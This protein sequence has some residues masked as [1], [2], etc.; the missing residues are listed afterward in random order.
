MRSG[1]ASPL[2][3]RLRVVV[4]EQQLRLL[5]LKPR[6]NRRRAGIVRFVAVVA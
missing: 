4:V 5:H 2:R 1:R 3:R 6:Q